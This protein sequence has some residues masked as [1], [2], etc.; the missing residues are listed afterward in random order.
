MT[1]KAYAEQYS[2][3]VRAK[4]EEMKRKPNQKLY[5]VT[6]TYG[7]S[8]EVYASSKKDARRLSKLAQI[9]SITVA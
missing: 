1:M 8:T 7:Y 9:Q 2:Q 4:E 3:M 6:T 5:R